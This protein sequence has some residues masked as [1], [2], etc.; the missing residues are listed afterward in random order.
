MYWLKY[1][2]SEDVKKKK[3][4]IIKFEPFY[5]VYSATRKSTLGFIWYILLKH[6][7]ISEFVTR[8]SHLMQETLGEL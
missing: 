4:E 7:A 2:F 3:K 5:V 8:L 6:S 1:C